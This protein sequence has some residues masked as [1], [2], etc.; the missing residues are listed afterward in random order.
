MSYNVLATTLTNEFEYGINPEYLKW[1]NR[2]P[3][4]K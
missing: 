4:I 3:A 2:F 1:E